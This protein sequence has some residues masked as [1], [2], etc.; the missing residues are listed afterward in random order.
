MRSVF[1]VAA[2]HIRDFLAAAIYDD[3]AECA[4]GAREFEFGVVFE[5]TGLTGVGVLPGGAERDLLRAGGRADP[6]LVAAAVGRGFA[7]FAQATPEGDDAEVGVIRVAYFQASLDE[8]GG[9]GRWG[10]WLSGG[11]WPGGG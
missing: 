4:R 11:P 2:D 7:G 5:F 6:E 10:G 8:D 3:G 9:R 1:E